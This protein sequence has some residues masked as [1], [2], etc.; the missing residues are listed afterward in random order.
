MVLPC[1]A[2][3]GVKLARG[4]G[5]T[6]GGRCARAAD[7]VSSAANTPRP[8]DSCRNRA[9]RTFI[10]SPLISAAIQAPRRC[11][12]QRSFDH[13]T[14]VL[15]RLAGVVYIAR[16]GNRVFHRGAGRHCGAAVSVLVCALV[17]QAAAAA[18]SS[19]PER[20]GTELGFAVFQQHCVSCHGNKAFERAPSP[21]TLRSMSPER[22][23]AA[24]TSGIMKS[25]GDTLTEVD[26]RRVAE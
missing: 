6:R 1:A 7:W 26:R 4:A 22:I 17:A 15:L 23:Y 11:P 13:S 3:S 12:R 25:V 2:C 14:A 18:D 5:S 20:R 16:G 21:A 10:A 24:L 9:C 19:A 8:T